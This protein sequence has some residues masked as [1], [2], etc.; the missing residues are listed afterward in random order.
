MAP[1]G[2]S[3]NS[4]SSSSS[5]GNGS[6]SASSSNSSSSGNSSRASVDSPLPSKIVIALYSNEVSSLSHIYTIY[7]NIVSFIFLLSI[8]H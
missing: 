3:G 1:S 4:N 8:S 5:N 2:K 6:N 7:I